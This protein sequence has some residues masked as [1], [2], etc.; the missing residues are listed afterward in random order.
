MC[1]TPGIWGK[2]PA[3][4]VD[5]WS[6]RPRIELWAVRGGARAGPAQSL[7]L[8]HTKELD[9]CAQAFRRGVG[10]TSLVCVCVCDVCHAR[11]FGIGVIALLGVV[12]GDATAQAI[13][14]DRGDYELEVRLQCCPANPVLQ[15]VAFYVTYYFYYYVIKMH[16]AFGAS[17]LRF[18]VSFFSFFSILNSSYLNNQE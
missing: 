14:F 18:R 10:G 7:G 17:A 4:F 16:E 8:T 6:S 9:I 13:A 5:L 15:V 3:N 2:L 12:A 1:Q 11:C